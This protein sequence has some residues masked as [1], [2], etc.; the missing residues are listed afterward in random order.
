[1][2]TTILQDTPH[3]VW[4][5]L[6][7]LTVMG[8]KQTL[9]RR[10][11]LRSATA[12]PLVMVLLSLYGIASAFSSQPLALLAW[13]T[14][15]AVTLALS[16][17]MRVWSGIRWLDAERSVLMPGSWLPLALLLGLFLFKYSIGFTL[18][19][20]PALAADAGVAGFAGLVYGAFSGVF[21]ARALAV[22]RAVRQAL[23]RDT[24]Y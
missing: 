24:V 10:R 20:N 15:L 18:A 21:L 11:S 9:P 6:A 4:G 14:G 19:T 13:V 12:L 16:Q 3:W 17:G 2:F 22:W 7:A 23:P 8:F 1:M 5:V